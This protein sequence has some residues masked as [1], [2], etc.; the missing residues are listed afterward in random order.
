MEFAQQHRKCK[1]YSFCT[2]NVT[3]PT[4]TPTPTITNKEAFNRQRCNYKYVDV[5][6]GALSYS[7]HIQFFSQSESLLSPIE[8]QIIIKREKKE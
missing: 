7:V 4:S 8:N 2:I 5:S 3:P 1:C 6:T